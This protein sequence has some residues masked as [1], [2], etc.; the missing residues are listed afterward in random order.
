[1]KQINILRKARGALAAVKNRR[2][3]QIAVW[4]PVGGNDSKNLRLNV[5]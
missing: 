5:T 3:R 4:T 2:S 1:M